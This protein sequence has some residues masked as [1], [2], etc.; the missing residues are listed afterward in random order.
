MYC[1]HSCISCSSPKVAGGEHGLSIDTNVSL[2]L[3]YRAFNDSTALRVI[4]DFVILTTELHNEFDDFKRNQIS[5]FN[6]LSLLPVTEL[7]QFWST[8]AEVS[9]ASVLKYGKTNLLLK[10]CQ[11]DELSDWTR[12]MRIMFMSLGQAIFEDK[13]SNMSASSNANGNE[14]VSPK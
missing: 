4:D 8:L 3:D 5:Q 9:P 13:E 12:E 2:W 14:S 7:L 6:G 10:A 11:L 1:Y